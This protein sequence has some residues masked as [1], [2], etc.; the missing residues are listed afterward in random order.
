MGERTAEYLLYLDATLTE[1]AH[2]AARGRA[3]YDSD[4]AVARACQY[5]IIRLTI[6]LERLGEPWLQAHP[7]VPW[8]VIRGMRNRVAH[9]YLTVN[10]DIVWAVV[11][12]HAPELRQVL[13][14]EI[15]AA[16]SSLDI[17]GK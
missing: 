10:D 8:S 1:I 7:D 13:T 14:A 4:I 17:G 9:D 12:Q 6:D 5:S 16:R 11:T 2:L 3:A 15:D